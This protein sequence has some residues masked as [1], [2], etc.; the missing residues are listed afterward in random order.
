MRQ[1]RWRLAAALAV[2]LVASGAVWAAGDVVSEVRRHTEP[3]QDVARAR[4]DG[5]VQAGGMQAL[6]GIHFVN[7][8]AQLRAAALGLD[9]ASPSMLLYVERAGVFRLA[10]VEYALPSRPAGG[11]LPAAA[12]HDHEAAC[13]YRDDREWPAARAGDCPLRHPSSEAPFVLWH[14]AL[15]VA[16]VWA[17]ID[18]PAGPFALTNAA[19]APWGGA[20]A[21]HT[22]PRTEA[23]SAYSTLN[24]R[25]SGVFLLMIAIVVWWERRRPRRLPWSAASAPLWMAFSVYLFLSVDPEAWPVG[26]GTIADALADGLVVQHKVLSAIPMVIG[27][28]ELLA[29]SGVL[30]SPRWRLVLPLLAFLGGASLFVHTHDGAF[31]LDRMFLNHAL[32]GAAAIAGAAILYVVQRTD[33]TRALL[34]R[35]WP[36]LLAAI[37]L[38][39]LVYSER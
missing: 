4:A 22:H 11:P 34:H 39:L 29:R 25:V 37:A 3:Y 30:R 13:H 28:V 7:P 5:F 21:S 35:A 12:W 33:T 18:N 6:H 36:T 23:E 15:A 20:R 9:L 8:A 14:P 17:W 2:V 27:V 24:H 16:H 31:H 19:L 1:V 26:P 32:L 38:L 10:G